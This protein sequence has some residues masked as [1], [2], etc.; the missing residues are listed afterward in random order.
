MCAASCPYTTLLCG[1]KFEFNP[2][3][4]AHSIVAEVAPN[5]LQRNHLRNIQKHNQIWKLPTQKR[6]HISLCSKSLR[7][8]K[9]TAAW[10][11]DCASAP[12]ARTSSSMLRRAHAVYLR[13]SVKEMVFAHEHCVK[14]ARASC[15]SGVC[16]VF[17]N[18][19]VVH[20]WGLCMR[21]A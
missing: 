19:A 7:A 3:A 12:K 17:Q 11:G 2:I 21:R 6:I 10:V 15:E 18:R 4:P 1:R 9:I 8:A 14:S 16:F 20:A 13:T 5:M